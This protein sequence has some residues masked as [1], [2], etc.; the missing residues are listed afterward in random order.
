MIRFSCCTANRGS[1]M[2]HT[3]LCTDGQ[4][5]STVSTYVLHALCVLS[6]ETWVRLRHGYEMGQALDNEGKN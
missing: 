2:F 1:S 4:K 3:T 5:L 6:S